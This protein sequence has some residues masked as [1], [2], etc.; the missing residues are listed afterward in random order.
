[1]SPAALNKSRS[2]IAAAVVDATGGTAELVW[3][4]ED[5]VLAAGAEPWTQL[6]CWV[7]ENEEF[8]GFMEG[9][10]SQAIA[11]GLRTR[12]VGD[13]VRDTWTWLQ[14]AGMPVQRPDRPGHGLPENLE[15]ELLAGR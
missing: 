8:A 4:P 14:E 7:P 3:V 10:T 9:D 11:T 12:P 13:T 15:R 5:E 2:S 6:P 1:M